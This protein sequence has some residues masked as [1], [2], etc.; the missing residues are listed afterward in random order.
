MDMNG[1]CTP[2]SWAGV[3]PRIADARVEKAVYAAGQGQPMAV[4]TMGNVQET[5]SLVKERAQ[6]VR[7][8]ADALYQ[9]VFGEGLPVENGLFVPTEEVDPGIGLLRIK[10]TLCTADDALRAALRVF[11]DMYGRVSQ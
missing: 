10:R 11:E 2:P 1:K 6:Q 8:V 7:S 5:A 3:D 4:L 9:I